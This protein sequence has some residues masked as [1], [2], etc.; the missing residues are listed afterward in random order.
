M[1]QDRGLK[2]RVLRYAVAKRW[3][4]QLELGVLPRM[5]T[6]EALK[7]LTDIDVVASVPD[8]F[9]GY[10]TLVVDCKSGR[11]ESAIGRALWLRGVMDQFHATRGLCVL[12]KE[13][14]EPDHRYSAAQMGVLLLA[15]DEF[16]KYAVATGATGDASGSYL[17][18]ID[19]WERFFDIG[20]QYRA[21]A[22]SVQFS[23]SGY[24]M[25]SSESEACRRTIAEAVRIRPEVDP[26]K[27]EHISL[28]LDL[29]A[30]FMHS[31]SRLV[32][33]L[34]ASYLQP[35][36]RDELSNA[37]LTLLYGGR[38]NYEHLNALK[39]LISASNPGVQN[40]KS[41]TLPEWDR[42]LQ[43]ARHGLDS[44][45]ELPHAALLLRELAWSFLVEKPSLGFAN[46]LSG[47]KRQ[48]AKMALMGAE[49]ISHAG[50]L[51][52]EFG[53]IATKT[54]LELQ[55]LPS[56]ATHLGTKS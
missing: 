15:E 21:L 55:R 20:T 24:W 36:N 47:E 53:T 28:I 49:Y 52:P 23:S 33:K 22:D 18:Q 31:V 38:E 3:F 26:A 5:S 17:A 35:D 40:G 32:A 8:E 2:A 6:T 42:F 10:R 39:K 37:L 51:P 7:P 46:T 34:F 45:I 30:L 43:L 16:E 56:Q 12:V 41:L 9:D 25:C 13:K 50:K 54:L 44:P 29:S 27:R 14:I 4:P 48:A 1:I 19:I 11:R